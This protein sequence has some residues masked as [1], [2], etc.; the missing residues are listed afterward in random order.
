MG[1]RRDCSEYSS[2]LH[3]KMSAG[4]LNPSVKFQPYTRVREGTEKDYSSSIDEGAIL[5]ENQVRNPDESLNMAS[6]SVNAEPTKNKMSD[7]SS[8]VDMVL[9]YEIPHPSTVD[10]D[11]ERQVETDKKQIRD[12]YID[13]LKKADLVIE[14]NEL[15]SDKPV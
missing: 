7:G 3:R 6:P 1:A 8:I 13:G 9:V 2:I 15:G 14:V 11:K 4:D 12:F 5:L 10:T